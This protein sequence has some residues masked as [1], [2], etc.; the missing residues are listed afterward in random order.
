MVNTCERRPKAALVDTPIVTENTAL[1]GGSLAGVMVMAL[2][3]VNC[4]RF[5]GALRC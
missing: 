5:P 2:L 1:A 3:R 4:G